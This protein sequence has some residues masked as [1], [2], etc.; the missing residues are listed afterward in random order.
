MTKRQKKSINTITPYHPTK[1]TARVSLVLLPFYSHANLHL[2]CV[3]VP[4]HPRGIGSASDKK[5]WGADVCLLCGMSSCLTSLAAGR[6]H[7]M[8]DYE[9]TKPNVG[10]FLTNR[11]ANI[12]LQTLSIR[13]QLPELSIEV[14]FAK[15]QS[16][17]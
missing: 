7:S 13:R 16:S 4:V 5:R 3:L 9:A 17:T 15:H 12:M 10:R 8:C 1:Q 11:C 14:N 6:Y 2:R